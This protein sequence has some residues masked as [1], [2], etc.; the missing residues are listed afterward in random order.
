[1]ACSE[2]RCACTAQAHVLALQAA[3]A[4]VVVGLM[5]L[6]R[7]ARLATYLVDFYCYRPPDRCLP[8]T[9]PPF[10]LSALRSLLLSRSV[11]AQHAGLPGQSWGTAI[12]HS[13]CAQRRELYRLKPVCA[14]VGC[15]NPRENSIPKL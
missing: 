3:M 8:G 9:A 12:R 14:C 7:P 4:V 6:L 2:Q 15:A 11:Q 5:M 10:P 1:M 13:V